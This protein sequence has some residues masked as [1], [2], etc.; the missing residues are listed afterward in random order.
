MRQR[1]CLN[2]ERKDGFVAH[3]LTAGVD[4]PITDSRIG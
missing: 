3:G 2:A 1:R 4:E